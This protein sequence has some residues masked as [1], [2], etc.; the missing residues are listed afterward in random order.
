MVIHLG[1]TLARGEAGIQTQ[2]RAPPGLWRIVRLRLST[3]NPCRKSKLTPPPKERGWE[4]RAGRALLFFGFLPLNS[5][6][7]K[8]ELNTG[9]LDF[10][11]IYIVCIRTVC[12]FGSGGSQL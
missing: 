9:G 7:R 12:L 1:H 5:L 4:L 6:Q 10:F 8:A 3:H 2:A 11:L